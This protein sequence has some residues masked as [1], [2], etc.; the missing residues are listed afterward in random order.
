[1][2]EGFVDFFQ[3]RFATFCAALLVPAT[4][5]WFTY[6]ERDQ[7]QRESARAQF[8]ALSQSH[9]N[10]IDELSNHLV[11]G[12]FRFLKTYESIDRSGFK[13]F[14]ENEA[15]KHGQKIPVLHQ[16]ER[17]SSQQIPGELPD[18]TLSV[19]YGAKLNLLLESLRNLESSM[20]DRVK[21]SKLARETLHFL[22]RAGL[23]D[24]GGLFNTEADLSGLDLRGLNIPC[25]SLY[26][27]RIKD[28]DFSEANLSVGYLSSSTDFRNVDF[29]N[30]ILWSS[31]LGKARFIGSRFNSANLQR[32]SLKEASLQDSTFE[33]AD[34]REAN[35]YGA[36]VLKGN[37]FR[38][39]D[40]RGAVLL[41]DREKSVSGRAFEGAF[42]NSKPL[43]LSDSTVI[44]ATVI[45]EG[46]TFTDLEL[47]DIIED[48]K[49]LIPKAG[50]RDGESAGEIY[51]PANCDW[52]VEGNYA[53]IA[54]YRRLTSFSSQA[55]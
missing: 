12:D 27:L 30:S 1:M 42:A 2:S 10:F 51:L 34:M 48:N 6:W 7:S 25:S 22:R 5:V 29:T 53:L 47:I 41:F 54:L 26:G 4:G 9:K 15:R 23:L 19:I 44:P 46:L 40:M 16:F 24:Y 38:Y 55:N 31:W 52:K 49:S 33:R 45:P 21:A 28:T 11:S 32:V 14:I 36:R 50:T 3:K 35:L 43:K 20:A 37:S 13:H 18:S 39:A 8:E 17:S